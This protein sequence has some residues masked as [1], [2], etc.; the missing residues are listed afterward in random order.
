MN[1]SETRTPVFLTPA[2][3][4]DERFRDALKEKLNLPEDME[5]SFRVLEKIRQLNLSAMFIDD[6]S[7]IEYFYNL[8][9]LDVS[10]NSLHALDVSKLR[11][12]ESST[13]TTTTSARSKS[14][15]SITCASCPYGA[16]S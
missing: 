7:G 12:L 4:P 16:T 5:I 1:K 10:M 3:F 9:K 2:F 6:L 8:R 15:D 11:A 14:T 13:A